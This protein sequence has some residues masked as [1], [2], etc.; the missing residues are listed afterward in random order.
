M[1]GFLL[2]SYPALSF[3]MEGPVPSLEEFVTEA[4]IH[5]SANDIREIQR[6]TQLPPGGES[7]F[8]KAWGTFWAQAHNA[9]TKERTQR[10][11]HTHLHGTYFEHMG[12][13]VRLANQIHEAWLAPN[14]L[15]R[16]EAFLQAQWIWIDEQRRIAPSTQQDMLGFALQLGILEQVARWDDE[17]GRKTF[18]QELDKLFSPLLEHLTESPHE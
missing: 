15:M 1:Y 8:A 14:P 10:L 13:D 18:D 3:H 7:R 6:I 11:V 9:I 2:S 17:L 5:V 16:E 12:W 4:Q